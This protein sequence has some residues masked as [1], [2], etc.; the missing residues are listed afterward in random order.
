[1]EAALRFREEEV[2]SA[3]TVLPKRMALGA[4]ADET[5]WWRAAAPPRCWMCAPPLPRS[6][7]APPP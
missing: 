5:A 2:L 6:C 3:A 4:T 1:M 7:P